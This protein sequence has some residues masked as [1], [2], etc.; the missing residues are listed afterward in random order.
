MCKH[1]EFIQKTNNGIVQYTPW[2]D[3]GLESCLCYE[4]FTTKKWYIFTQNKS[5]KVF[6]GSSYIYFCP[7]CGKKLSKNS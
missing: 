6:L 1:C 5:S 7:R 2:E 3:T 4:K